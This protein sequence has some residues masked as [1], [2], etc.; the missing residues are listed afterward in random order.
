MSYVEKCRRLEFLMS[1]KELM[2]SVS[3]ITYNQEEYIAQTIESIVNQKHDYPYELIIGD[4]ASHDR[5]PEIIREYAEKYPDIIKLIFNQ[6]NMGILKNFSNV[7]SHCKGKYIMECAGDD[8]WLPGKVQ[9]QISFMEENSDV[10]MCYGKVQAYKSGRKSAEF[11][12]IKRET[13]DELLYKGNII[14]AVTVC[15]K[16]ELYENYVKE[17]KPETQNW[18][19][20]D[21]P[22]WLYMSHE[23][24]IRFLNEKFACYRILPCSASHNTNNIEKALAFQKSFWNIQDFFSRRYFDK[25]FEPFNEHYSRALIYVSE[26]NMK[27]ARKEFLQSGINDLKTRIYV[28]VCSSGILFMMYRL[29]MK[30]KY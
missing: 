3:L 16:R 14:P 5:T 25:Q 11:E 24:K 28:A 4:D 6:S 8:W 1:E 13:F 18:L 17:I 30:I 7:L 23:S 27:L 22:M 10:G 2:F 19:M 21:Y 29:Y 12:G 9:K 15:Y 20:E 26:K